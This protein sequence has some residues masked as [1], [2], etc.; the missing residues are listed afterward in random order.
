MLTSNRST[1]VSL[2][3]ALLVASAATACTS[4]KAE[5]SGELPRFMPPKA[6]CNLEP[7]ELS[8]SEWLYSGDAFVIGTIQSV[9]PALDLGWAP[10]QA[11]AS[12]AL[13]NA[14]ACDTIEHGLVVELRDVAM[15]QADASA[16]AATQIYVGYDQFSYWSSAPQMQNGRLIWPA[17]DEGRLD[18]GMQIAA[19]L[20]QEKKTGRWGVP[21]S[22]GEPLF[23]VRDGLLEPQ[24]GVG[25]RCGGSIPMGKLAG[26]SAE[27]VLQELKSLAGAPAFAEESAARQAQ[28]D[29]N[30]PDEM[31]GAGTWFAYCGV[32]PSTPTGTDCETHADCRGE[33]ICEDGF[34]VVVS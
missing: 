18:E 17:G 4:S 2:A 26:R 27:L 10:A 25:E 32:S 8:V 6:D 19:L 29:A 3:L 1:A 28:Q 15:V 13:L 33:E 24:P 34:C 7:F 21:L 5:H 23:L 12:A 31:I 20:L 16:P 14:K 9:R 11:G 30:R 22:H